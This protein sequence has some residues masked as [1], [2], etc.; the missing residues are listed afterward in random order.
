MRGRSDAW[1]IWLQLGV[2]DTRYWSFRSHSLLDTLC[3]KCLLAFFVC[4]Y[5][6]RTGYSMPR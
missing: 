3:C 5:L 2:Y 1:T 4:R 6:Q